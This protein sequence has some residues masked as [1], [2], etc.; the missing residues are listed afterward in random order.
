VGVWIGLSIGTTVFA[1]LL[2]WRFHALTRAGYMPAV[3]GTTQAAAKQRTNEVA[4]APRR[5][6]PE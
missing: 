1:L 4:G 6:R 3:A 5:G 2:T